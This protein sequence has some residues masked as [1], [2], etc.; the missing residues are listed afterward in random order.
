M[1]VWP[2]ASAMNQTDPGRLG[3]SYFP[4]FDAQN[5]LDFVSGTTIRQLTTIRPVR[6][7]VLNPTVIPNTLRAFKHSQHRPIE[8]A[9]LEVGPKHLKILD[10]SD[11]L[12]S[13]RVSSTNTTSLSVQLETEPD[14]LG[15]YITLPTHL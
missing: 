5:H 9:T 2:P 14:Y 13:L 3:S 1:P 12:S 8:L 15:S 6:P 4:R 7:T 10:D 11:T